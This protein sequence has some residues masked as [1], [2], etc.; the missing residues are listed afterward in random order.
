MMDAFR[1]LRAGPLL[2]V[3]DLGRYGL[4]R[5]GVPPSGVLDDYSGRIANILVGNSESMAVLEITYQG[6]RLEFLGR[7][8]VAV[9]GSEMPLTVN[10]RP[11]PLWTSFIVNSGDILNLGQ[12]A[13]GLRCY[14]AIAGGIDSPVI[15]GSR[16]TYTA[17]G[18]GPF[19]GRPLAA[20][21]VLGRGEVTWEPLLASFPP[22]LIPSFDSEVRLRAIPGPQDY[23]FGMGLEI[24]YSASY[25][26][27][28]L[29][30]RMGYRL[31][32]PA[33]HP[34]E[35]MPASIISEPSLPGA[36]QVPP[37][38]QPIIILLEQTTGG[39]AK[40]AHV[41]STDIAKLAQSR[42]GN[43]VTF[44]RVTLEEAQV[45]SSRQASLWRKWAP[46]DIKTG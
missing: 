19:G 17:A 43:R 7:A 42:P 37:D 12:A 39:Y 40:I 5:F 1:I 15:M 27:T 29:A 24:F 10:G 28:P 21:D 45:I 26:V 46:G 9:T 41:I 31:A 30:N 4:L 23:M 20:G 36:V 16:S 3:Q 38:G 11:Q 22:E 25:E 8:W 6:P 34:S 33:I 32:G 14:L 18:L 44:E 35:G 13:K 2:T